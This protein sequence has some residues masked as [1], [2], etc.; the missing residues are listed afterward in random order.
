VSLSDSSVL[1]L[2]DKARAGD[3]DAL[4]ALLDEYHDYLQQLAS[5]QLGRQ[6]AAR[7]AA[8]DLVQQTCLSVHQRIA[9][10]EGNEAAQF[11]A[12][13]RRIHERNI[14]NAIRD[15][16]QTQ[17]RAAGREEPLGERDV[18]DVDRTTASGRVLHGEE[19]ERLRRALD[20]LP[21]DQQSVLRLRYFEGHTLADV[22]AE[23]GI[24]KDAVLW[25]MQKAMKQV[26][27]SL[28]E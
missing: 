8:S 17:K 11:V 26:K 9:T 27:Q 15:Q 13:L 22:A 18:S 16:L 23:M 2:L 19:R 1:T 10:F 28:G 7:V 5:Q 21:S 4:G 20:E 14:Q 25:L 24:T 3:A 6:V 12:W